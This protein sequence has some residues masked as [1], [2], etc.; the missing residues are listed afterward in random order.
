MKITNLLMC[1]T[2]SL[3][4]PYHALLT[5]NDCSE[6]RGDKNKLFSLA[7]ETLTRV[8]EYFVNSKE[9]ASHL[10]G[11]VVTV[12]DEDDGV[13]AGGGT[14]TMGSYNSVLFNGTSLFPGDM[15]EAVPALS[16]DTRCGYTDSF[17]I[18]ASDAMVIYMC[19][20]PPTRYFSHDVLISARL[21]EEYPF[22]PGQPFGNAISHM[23][24][25][26]DNNESIYDEPFV[27]IHAADEDAVKRTTDAFLFAG[28]PQSQINV[29]YISPSTVRFWDRSNGQSNNWKETAPD[30]ISHVGRVSVPIEGYENEYELYKDIVWPAR[31]YFTNDDLIATNLVE[32]PLPSRYTPNI[33][34]EVSM[35]NDTLS[36]LHDAVVKAWVSFEH[37]NFLGT[38]IVNL[39]ALGYYDDWDTILELKN[40]DS[41]VA[42]TR[43]AT[44][45]IPIGYFGHFEKSTCG[46][47]IGVNHKFVNNISYNSVGLDLTSYG[48]YFETH[49]FL[50]EDLYGSAVRYLGDDNMLAP[51]LYAIDFYPPGGCDRSSTPKQWC[52]EFYPDNYDF[53]LRKLYPIIGERM[54]T[55]QET[56]LGNPANLTCPA[57]WLQFG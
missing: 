48:K 22:Y 6:L 23:T 32:P 29:R 17:L 8:D 19:T 15:C 16:G 21:T 10:G 57:M 25:H 5:S 20:P 3:L 45:G 37:V 52:V 46:T 51:Y 18:G 39:T 2:I 24:I 31:M 40:N 9:V 55:L 53:K 47:L 54:Y 27:L 30:I 35:L 4:K 42:G 33:V 11:Y 56:A 12:V 43:D 41:F 34:D 14:N 26:V 1:L 28:V 50:D 44:Y 49:W 13:D 36:L 7:E 38:Q